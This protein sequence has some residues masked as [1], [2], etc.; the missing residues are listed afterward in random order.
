MKNAEQ[1]AVLDA[2]RQLQAT[3]DQRI[4][5]L[6]AE[7]RTVM[8]SVESLRRTVDAIESRPVPYGRPK[9]FHTATEFHSV[10]HPV[11]RKLGYQG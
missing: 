8:G 5:S 7:M 6:E 9:I 4:G 1:E 2:I 3:V 10:S 11:R